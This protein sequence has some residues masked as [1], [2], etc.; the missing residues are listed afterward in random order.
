[1][2][3]NPYLKSHQRQIHRKRKGAKAAKFGEKIKSKLYIGPIYFLTDNKR[4]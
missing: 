2:V 4:N 1:M 3:V